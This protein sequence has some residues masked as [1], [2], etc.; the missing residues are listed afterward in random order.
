MKIILSLILITFAVSSSAQNV[1]KK[2]VVV[3]EVKGTK[4]MLSTLLAYHEQNL[5]VVRG[6]KTV[7]LNASLNDIIDRV[8]G[9]DNGRKA[10]IDKRPDVVK[11][12]NDIVYH[13]H[14]S[15]EIAPKLKSIKVS[16]SDIKKYYEKNPEYKS[17]QILI[18]LRALPSQDEVA[19]ALEISLKL[20]KELQKEPKS[21]AKL[22][23][24]HSQIS[25][26]QLGGDIGYQPRS[27]LSKEYY[28]AI[29]GRRISYI[30]KPFRT[31]YGIHI[32]KVTG[33]KKYKQIDK[34]LYKKIV[35]DVKRDKILA[36]YFAGERKKSGSKVYKDR[37]NLK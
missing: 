35:Y 33:E 20:Y 14:I 13:A 17:S 23:Q 29:N 34:D 2:D 7:D 30:T 31:Q 25:T 1:K 9:I 12:M 32:V 11:K 15:D 24:T 6:N 37:L 19:K 5:K 10:K 8:I 27:R 16:D 28:E 4:I 36:N 26:S 3:A 22:A 21:F 18:R